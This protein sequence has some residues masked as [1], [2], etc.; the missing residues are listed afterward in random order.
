MFNDPCISAIEQKFPR[1]AESVTL[2][3]GDKDF[4]PYVDKLVV[5]DR[6]DREGFPQ[7]VMQE[8]LFLSQMHERILPTRDPDNPMGK[9]MRLI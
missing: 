9:G 8:L 3:W 2:M 4:Q 5:D 7:D 1:L 6:G